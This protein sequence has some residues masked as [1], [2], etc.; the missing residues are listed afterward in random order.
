[1]LKRI[2]FLISFLIF[3]NQLIAQGFFVFDVS[4][5]AYTKTSKTEKQLVRKDVIEYPHIL[6]VKENASVILFRQNDGVPVTVKTSGI[7]NFSK[8]NQL[9]DDAKPK[10]TSYFLEYCKKEILKGHDEEINKGKGVVSR[11]RSDNEYLLLPLD[12]SLIINP[13]VTFCWQKIAENKP[14]FF[15][16]LDKD[17]KEV[18]KILT[19]DTSVTIFLLSS[20]MKSGENYT[21]LVT[22]DQN[23]IDDI[24]RYSFEICS[25]ENYNELNAR[26]SDF[27]NSLNYGED[28]NAIFLCQFYEQNHLYIE[29]LELYQS[30]ILKYSSNEILK[31]KFSQ[32][33]LQS[34]L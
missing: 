14:V 2:F 29:A 6:V 28:Y 11:G 33:M 21:W 5:F 19:N 34:G 4:G 26:L 1:M 9:A 13:S 15:I 17:N 24:D 30:T 8:L 32:F 27:R 18:I 22:H 31:G 20:G 3:F 16:I 23:L 25:P 12:S 7:Y 10:V